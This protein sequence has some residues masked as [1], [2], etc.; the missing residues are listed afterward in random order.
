MLSPIEELNGNY[1]AWC[2]TW[3]RPVGCNGEDDPGWRQGDF[4]GAQTYKPAERALSDWLVHIR[5]DAEKKNGETLEARLV[6]HAYHRRGGGNYL[7]ESYQNDDL[8]NAVLEA[9]LEA[10]H[11]E[12]YDITWACPS[13][14]ETKVSHCRNEIFEIVDVTPEERSSPEEYAKRAY[15][16]PARRFT[17]VNMG[18]PW[19][20][21]LCEAC[22]L[23][24]DGL[25][26]ALRARLMAHYQAENQAAPI[27]GVPLSAKAIYTEWQAATALVDELV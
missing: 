6:R 5:S 10:G 22:D 16:L 18:K 27:I 20:V 25:V 24:H 15:F 9:R 13:T 1:Q 4:R 21:K 14:G 26:P 3:E 19:L 17:F 11:G 2:A 8:F 7:C 23:E 12:P